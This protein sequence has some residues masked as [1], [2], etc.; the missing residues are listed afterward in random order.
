MTDQTKQAKLR[1]RAEG[2]TCRQARPPKPEAKSSYG[3]TVRFML[4]KKC[5]LEHH[6]ACTSHRYAPQYT[7]DADST[8][9]K[10][11]EEAE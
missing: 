6:V 8:L 4:C 11:C 2:A 10:S 3:K 9:C 1:G 5:G 7:L